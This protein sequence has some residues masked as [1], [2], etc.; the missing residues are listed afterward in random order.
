MSTV[1]QIANDI[2]RSSSYATEAVVEH[3]LKLG[4]TKT[5]HPLYEA[6][7]L[8]IK[9]N[10]GDFTPDKVAEHLH[11]LGYSR[12]PRLTKDEVHEAYESATKRWSAED[13]TVTALQWYWS[14]ELGGKAAD[15]LLLFAEELGVKVI[16]GTRILPGV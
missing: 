6:L 14:Q 13:P 3:L 9:S 7:L 15:L 10:E 8:D 4:Y 12:G 1:A 11:S 16:P 2:R 5:G